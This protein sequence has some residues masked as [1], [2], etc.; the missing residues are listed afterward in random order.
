V[1][2]EHAKKNFAYAFTREEPFVNLRQRDDGSWWI[3]IYTDNRDLVGYYAME[4][5]A[6]E[7]ISGL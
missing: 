3:Q 4:L 6:T 2:P 5:V 7:K 1:V